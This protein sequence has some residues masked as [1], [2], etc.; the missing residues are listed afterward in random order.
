MTACGGGDHTDASA[1]APAP[2]IDT[3]QVDAQAAS[4]AAQ[5]LAGGTP[6]ATAVQGALLA[7]GFA[8]EAPNGSIS[9]P[10]AAASQ[11]LLFS[12][13]DVD[14][15]VAGTG[16]GGFVTLDDLSAAIQVA[17][18]ELDASQITANILADIGADAQSQDATIRLWARL[19][20]E[21]GRQREAAY[22][23]LD[24]NV[25]PT[26][27]EL[28]P[29]KRTALFIRMNDLVVQDRAIVPVVSRPRVRASSLKL[30]VP[31]SGWDSDFWALQDWFRDVTAA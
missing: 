23:L 15:M 31:E 12:Q 30:R 28:D 6:T 4:L 14:A 24:P 27:V 22:D 21:L 17:F 13:W 10:D 25:D 3:A 16:S 7:T 2:A 8:I 26:Q 29:V 11:G 19:L 1:Q 5:I 9:R 18:P 20:V